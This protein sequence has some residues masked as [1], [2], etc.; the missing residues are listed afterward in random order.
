M[1]EELEMYETQ[2][3]SQKNI[4]TQKMLNV[5]NS[6]FHTLKQEVG[7]VDQQGMDDED[8]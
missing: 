2:Q 5:M 6:Y 4:A 8:Y 1:I 7:I 3:K